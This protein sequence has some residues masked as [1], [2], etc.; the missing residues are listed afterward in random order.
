MATV[1][2]SYKST[3]SETSK[4]ILETYTML[5]KGF[6]FCEIVRFHVEKY[7]IT[8]SAV[9][10]YIRNA[11]RKILDNNQD[12]IEQLRAEANTRY[13]GWLRKSESL[14]FLKDAAYM[15]SRMDKINGLDEKIVRIINE[16]KDKS[17]IEG[18]LNG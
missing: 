11:K 17:M 2:K 3:A 5:V 9:E 15:Q 12:E 6:A 13:L 1:K 10:K 7:G 16:N 14:G 18:L 4:R 8:Q